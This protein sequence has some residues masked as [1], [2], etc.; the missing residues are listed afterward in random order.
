MDLA[1]MDVEIVDVEQ[2]HYFSASWA[3]PR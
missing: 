1:V 3:A 2:R